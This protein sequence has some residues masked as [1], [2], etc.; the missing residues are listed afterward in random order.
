MAG[1]ESNHGRFSL[2]CEHLSKRNRNADSIQPCSPHCLS[3]DDPSEPDLVAAD[4]GR[5]DERRG[6]QNT[7]LLSERR[8]VF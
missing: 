3:W 2:Y 6:T 1:R 8:A 4:G 5:G 7:G